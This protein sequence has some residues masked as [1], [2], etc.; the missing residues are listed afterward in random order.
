M[1][2]PG[3]VQ[4]QDPGGWFS[5]AHMLLGFVPLDPHLFTR[6]HGMGKGRIDGLP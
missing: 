4:T 5:I 1:T 3:H 6:A 2:F